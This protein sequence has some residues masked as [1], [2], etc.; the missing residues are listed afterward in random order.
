M[1]KC[2]PR[3]EPRTHPVQNQKLRTRPV[4][5]QPRPVQAK[6]RTRSVLISTPRATLEISAHAS[7]TRPLLETRAEPKPRTRSV[8][9]TRA[10]PLLSCTARAA[11]PCAEGWIRTPHLHGPC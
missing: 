9:L 7:R 8:Q 10:E 1:P 11:D 2:T 6:Y 3:A 5:S 4:Q